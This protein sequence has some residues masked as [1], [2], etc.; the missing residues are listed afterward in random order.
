MTAVE[1]AGLV[2]L[3]PRAAT[4]KEFALK[5]V[6]KERA[7]AADVPVLSGSPVVASATGKTATNL[8]CRPELRRAHFHAINFCCM[9]ISRGTVERFHSNTLA[10]KVK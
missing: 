6:A 9:H 8:S 10:C 3:G 2:W 1:A 5:H 4:M 7:I